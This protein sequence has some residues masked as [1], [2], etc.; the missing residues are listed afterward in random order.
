VLLSRFAKS[1][2]DWAAQGFPVVTSEQALERWNV[3]RGTETTERCPN[4]RGDKGFGLVACGS[5]GCTGL[6][7]YIK[8]KGCPSNKWPQL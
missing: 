2:I 5:C 1:M 6:A 4:Y 7:I 3:C 8:T